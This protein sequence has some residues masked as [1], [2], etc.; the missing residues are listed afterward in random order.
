MVTWAVSLQ[1]KLAK[2]ARY[3]KSKNRD[4]RSGQ[5]L[6]YSR[7]GGGKTALEQKVQEARSLTDGGRYLDKSI[8]IR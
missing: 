8:P 7:T 6:I 1:T 4:S 5:W 3:N 2:K